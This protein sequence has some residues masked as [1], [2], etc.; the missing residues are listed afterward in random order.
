MLKCAY[1]MK[2]VYMNVEF[3]N[4]VNANTV[5]SGTVRDGIRVRQSGI[6]KVLWRKLDREVPASSIVLGGVNIYK[7]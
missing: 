2:I 5:P 1:R 4:I 3:V 7:D 6:A